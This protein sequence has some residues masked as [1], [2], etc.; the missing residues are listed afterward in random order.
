ITYADSYYYAFRH[1]IFNWHYQHGHYF[2]FSR[3]SGKI[4]LSVTIKGQDDMH[5]VENMNALKP[6]QYIGCPNER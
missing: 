6:W 4:L 1:Y 2:H 5:F 3:K